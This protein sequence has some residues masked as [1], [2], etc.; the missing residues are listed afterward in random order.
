MI[1]TLHATMPGSKFSNGYRNGVGGTATTQLENGECTESSPLIPTTESS[2][3][4]AEHIHSNKST[5]VVLGKA[6]RMLYVSHLFAQFSE[7]AWQFCIILFLAAFSNYKSLI[8]VSTYGFVSYLSVCVFGSTAGRFIDKADRLFVAQRFIWSENIAVLV[9][10]L[11]CYVLLASAQQQDDD[12]QSINYNPS[13]WD[14]FQGVPTDSISIALLVGVHIL[15][16]TAQILDKG[17]LVAMERDWIVVMSRYPLNRGDLTQ[18]EQVDVQKRWLSDTNV[19]MKQIDLSCKIAAPAVAGYFIALLDD[20]SDSHHG[21]DLGGAALLVGALNGMA[22][23]VEYICTKIIYDQIP[24]LA[25]RTTSQ[26]T[27]GE[28]DST[29]RDEENGSSSGGDV[30]SAKQEK[31][32]LTNRLCRLPDS[33]RVYL[34]QPVSWAGIGLSLL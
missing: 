20:G 34:R 15:G 6:R 27:P 30:A 21:S 2:S 26:S 32:S 10:T 19:A 25:I 1:S 14:R 4:S 33:L 5:D 11:F 18:Q 28:D 24:D 9:A 23:I 7:N 17:F 12:T 16:A 3:S 29:N 13:K 31:A 8:L 22:L